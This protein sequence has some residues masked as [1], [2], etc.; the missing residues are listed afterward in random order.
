MIR[1]GEISSH[2]S[3]TC[4]ICDEPSQV[5]TGLV[6]IGRKPQNLGNHFSKMYKEF[7]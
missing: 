4:T 5:D 3:Q 6:L 7:V 2:I 1:G